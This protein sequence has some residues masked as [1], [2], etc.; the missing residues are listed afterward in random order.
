MHSKITPLRITIKNIFINKFAFIILFLFL[1]AGAL[2]S[3]A[4][5]DGHESGKGTTE[6]KKI[7]KYGEEI[8]HKAEEEFSVIDKVVDHNYIDF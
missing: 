7:E 2:N 5:E 3:F 8:E 6:E 1:S 4:Q